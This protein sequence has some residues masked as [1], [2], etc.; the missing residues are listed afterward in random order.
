M[1]LNASSW[2]IRNPVA[3]ILLFV[4]LTLLGLMAFSILKVQNF[5]DID[6]PTVTVTAAL[7]GA[8]PV[9]LE[10]D[11][12]RRIEDSLATLQGIKHIQSAVTDGEVNISVEFRLDKPT[13]E[14]RCG[15]PGARRPACR[16]ARPSDKE[17][18]TGRFADPDLQHRLDT[19]GR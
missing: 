1:N 6:V 17:G 9:Q 13:Q 19:H 4:L 18:R 8:S 15:F 3:V 16:P 10:T 5:P 12:A 11:V 2:A 7:P 14:A